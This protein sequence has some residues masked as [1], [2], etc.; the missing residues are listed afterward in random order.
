MTFTVTPIDYVL[1]TLM[2]LTLPLDS[3]FTS[4]IRSRI[5]AGDSALRTRAYLLLI[6]MEW[7]SCLIVLGLWVATGRPWAALMLGPITPWRFGL[8]MLAAALGLLPV[9]NLRRRV[10]N[11]M[12]NGGA[13][14]VRFSPALEALM[15][16][17]PAQRQLWTI[18]SITAGCCEEIICR[19]FLL[20]FIA[21][22]TGILM[23]VPISAIVF[24]LGHAYQGKKGI[25]GTG[26]WGLTA[27]IIAVA[28]ASLWPV[29][30]MHFLQDLLA[31][32]LGY[33]I[34]RARTEHAAALRY[35]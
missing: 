19:G 16:H 12:R 26:I 24:G 10:F 28:A 17:T 6:G 32:D 18:A 2:L 14:Q 23:A 34:V 35:E 13:Q 20:S 21:H 22:F 1:V 29:I 8:G 33:R 3:L 30:L 25:I 7:A 15:P 9:F 11:R 5:E 31:G 27:G 4:R